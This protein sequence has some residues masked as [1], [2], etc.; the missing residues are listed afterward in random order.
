MSNLRTLYVL[1]TVLSTRINAASAQAALPHEIY[2]VVNIT[3]SSVSHPMGTAAN[4]VITESLFV[5]KSCQDPTT[6]RTIHSIVFPSPN[7]SPIEITAQS[8]VITSYIPEMTWCVAP[9]VFAYALTGPPYLNASTSYVQSFEGTGSCETSYAP[10]QTTI[11][12]TTLT[13]LGSKISVTACDQEIT[14]STEYGFTLET[15]TPT[16]TDSSSLITPAPI[17]KRSTTYWL[18]PWQA[19]T[20]GDTPTD[21]DVKICSALDDDNM[22][23]TRY[24]EVWEVV[25]VTSTSTTQRTIQFSTTVTGPGTLHVETFQSTVTD[26]VESIDLSTVLMLETEVETESISKGRRP[27]TTIRSTQEITTTIFITKHLHHVSSR[28]EYH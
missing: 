20:A 3:T 13:G 14:F 6:T 23:C 25:V 15:P 4:N 18:A 22:E 12:A 17:V 26:T 7:A 24:Q 16:T 28:Y 5:T 19:L 9:A 11:C 27:S 21:V 10:L 1:L 8:Q 2:N